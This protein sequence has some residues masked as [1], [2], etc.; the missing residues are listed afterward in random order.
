MAVRSGGAQR[1]T[2]APIVCSERGCGARH[3]IREAL[4]A[5]VQADPSLRDVSAALKGGSPKRTTRDTAH[6]FTTP[7]AKIVWGWQIPQTEYP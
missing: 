4:N 7:G 1:E 6:G 5:T 2:H 3:G